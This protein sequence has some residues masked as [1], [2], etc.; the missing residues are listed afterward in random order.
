MAVWGTVNS[1]ILHCYLL[2]VGLFLLDLSMTSLL[3]PLRLVVGA[4]GRSASS[5]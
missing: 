2:I 1:S 5:T 3:E 4:L